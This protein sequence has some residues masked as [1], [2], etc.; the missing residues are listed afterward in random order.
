[1][2]DEYREQ[3]ACGTEYAD[4]P[5]REKPAFCGLND[6]VLHETFFAEDA[7][8]TSFRCFKSDDDGLGEFNSREDEKIFY[9]F[10]KMLKGA[11]NAEGENIIKLRTLCS[12]MISG[13]ASHELAVY[14]LLEMA[15]EIA[16]QKSMTEF[17][18]MYPFM[19]ASSRMTAY[20]RRILQQGGCAILA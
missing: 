12:D 7:L 5:H 20:G 15:M 13:G 14:A 6:V 19:L 8:A 16:S 11:W 2:I 9:F 4:Y 18:A 10:A 1:M 17:Q 3:R